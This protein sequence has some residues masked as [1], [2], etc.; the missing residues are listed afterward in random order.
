MAQAE[1]TAWGNL[2]GIRLEGQLIPFETSLCALAPD[3]SEVARTAKERQ[4][5]RFSRD[6]NR[7]TVATALRALVATQVVEDTG[8]GTAVV[9]VTF[10]ADSASAPGGSFCVDLPHAEFGNARV[11]WIGRTGS[12][13]N[14]WSRGFR[15]A[16][17]RRQLEV[18]FAEPAPVSV[19]PVER[20]GARWT[21]VAV[22][23]LPP[24]AQP[25]ATGRN[26]FSLRAQGQ[27]DRNP[28]QIT[29]DPSRPGRAFAGLGGNFRIQNPALDTAVIR[30]NLD[31]LR[32]AWGRVE[33]PWRFWHPEQQEQP[34]TRPPEQL[35]PRVRAAMEMA[36]DLARR[37]IPVVVGVWFPPQWAAVGE[38]RSEHP[39]GVR[40][41][42]LDP[43]RMEQ[44]YESIFQYLA[45]QKRHF[46]VETELF[47]FNESDLG[48]DVRQTPEQH[49]DFIKGFGA[50]VAARGLRTRMLLGD[51]SDATSTGFIQ[52]ALRDPAAWP[53]IGAVSFHSWRGWSDE[54]LRFWGDAA[55][56]LNVP[57][58]IGEGS[59][60]AGAW[61]YPAVF[62][63]PGFAREEINLY[64]RMLALAE[65]LSILQWQ[66]TA[67]YSIL[68]GGGLWGDSTALRPTQRFWNLKQLAATPAGAFA[69]PVACPAPAVTCAA[70]GDI[71]RGGYTVH[72]VND[73]ASRPATLGG[74]P[75]IIT[76]LRVL[77]TDARRGMEQIARV[78]VSG[79]TARFTLP[80]TSFVTLTN[81]Q[82]TSP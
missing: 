2:E 12:G 42:E 44:I 53:F 72:L 21:R 51:N 55:R 24:G 9:Q 82:A 64:L 47:S 37:D 5:P 14:M 67:D 8:P 23:V 74:V 1:A 30:Y 32:V 15:V 78:P 22:D 60:D 34:W 16:A 6:G 65:P 35:A 45:Y 81:A 27:I 29:L 31:N 61:R 52:P 39:G 48:I 7:R 4:R 43:A 79:G 46:G 63:E 70:F 57:L 36:R 38:V 56:R 40:G 13:G 77:V 20:Q 11:E 41:N 71:A 19:R 54:L 62:Q 58:L 18:R 80:A 28:V 49:R 26:N 75:N 66:L 73:G 17:P 59:T 76:E 3:G 50:Y 68:A 10:H 25:G 33:M 69:L